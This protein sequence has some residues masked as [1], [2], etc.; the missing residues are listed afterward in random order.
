[1]P[2]HLKSAPNK[3]T[4]SITFQTSFI[5]ETFTHQ[6][7]DKREPEKTSK[8]GWEGRG[9]EEQWQ[10]AAMDL[11]GKWRGNFGIWKRKRGRGVGIRGLQKKGPKQ[12]SAIFPL[13]PTFFSSL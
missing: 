12:L 8:E 4:N 10:W 5:F 7:K 6:T 9:L 1:M 3:I 11:G 13:F 2:C